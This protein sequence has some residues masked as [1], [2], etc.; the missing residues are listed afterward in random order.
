VFFNR[1]YGLVRKGIDELDLTV[2]ERAHFGASDCDHAD[3]FACVDQ[4]DGER[5][6]RT[7]LKCS[8]P[9]LGVFVRFGQDVCNMYCSPVDDGTR[10]NVPTPEGKEL[11]DCQPR[12]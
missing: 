12:R 2:G 10:C 6:A 4:G 9:A 5:G 1:D 3:C 8:L 11:S 7:G